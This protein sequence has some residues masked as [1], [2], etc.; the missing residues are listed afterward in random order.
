MKEWL[1][2]VIIAKLEDEINAV[3][4]AV[5]S[6]ANLPWPKGAEKIRVAC[7]WRI[8]QGDYRIVYSK[9]NVN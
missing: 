3:L 2:E 4:D 5:K 8:R 1:T 9:V 7:L 6:L